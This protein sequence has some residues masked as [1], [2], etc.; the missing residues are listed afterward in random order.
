MSESASAPG[1]RRQ[2]LCV[3][4]SPIHADARVLRQLE[5][6]GQHGEVTTVGYGPPPEGATKHIE[7]PK[8]ASS[9]PQTLLGVAKLALHLH[10]SVELSAP[11]EKAVLRQ[12]L[13]SGPYD[14]VVAN[15]ARALPL[16]FAA[17]RDTPVLA[18][19][20]EWAAQE[21]A[22]I[23]VW[24]WLVGPYMEH[25]C[26]KYLPRTAAVTTVSAG[27]AKL[28][29][30]HYGPE[31]G[32]V[33]STPIFQD[34]TPQPVDPATIRLVHSGIADDRRNLPALIE[35]V[36]RLNG[37]FTL[38]LYLVEVPGGHLEALR[39]QAN[40]SPLVTVHAPV[41]PASLPSVLN[42]YDLGVFLFPI[43]T[44]SQLHHLPNKFFDFVQA[45][46]GLVFAPAPETDAYI[47]EHGLGIVTPGT[48]ADALVGALQDLTAED[49]SGFK[50]A[51]DRAARSL[52]S[53]TDVAYQHELIGAL[54]GDDQ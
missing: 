36:N 4:F 29:R 38:D 41:L 28:Y 39:A 51:A 12:A 40:A 33:R 48:S 9:L 44:L 20:H 21:T 50:A 7:V 19:M 42:Q 25:L 37:R 26:R 15:D 13:D 32:V 34:L 16:A 30:E 14:L 1:H 52:S 23:W 17:S 31:T 45:R 49:V 18:D 5:V 3:S 47:R 43:K 24:R 8:N 46:I 35:A 53:E 54:L 10:E 22:T 6:L 11:G 27:L 2:I